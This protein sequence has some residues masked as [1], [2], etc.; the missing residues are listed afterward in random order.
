MSAIKN[1]D[2]MDIKDIQFLLWDRRIFIIF[3]VAISACLATLYSLSIPNTYTSKA[4]VAPVDSSQSLS[5]KLGSLS[6]IAAFSPIAL[7]GENTKA[8]EAIERIKSFDFFSKHF[9]SNI[10]L[11]DLLAVNKWIKEE[12]LIEY[13]NSIYS[14][15]EKKWLIDISMQDAY[16]I[17]LENIS[18][19]Q[20]KSTSFY[21]L[22]INHQSPSIAK[23]WVN[24]ILNNIDD[25]MRRRDIENS[26]NSID[27]LNKSFQLT[28][29]Q[30][31]KDA[32]SRLLESQMQTHMLASANESYVFKII[33][34]AIVPEK[35]SGPARALICIFGTLTGFFLSIIMVFI[36]ES[37]KQA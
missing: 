2:E 1:Y 15:N 24:I 17:Y 31:L 10:K 20:D 12:D 11:E 34:S 9:A 18:I 30:S 6:A 7:P 3:A 32:A 37:T 27:Y 19:K 5:S 4:I 8:T 26:Q 33:D 25:S 23:E 35:K 14:S 29:I 28:N 36:K 16:S 13:D 22:A 21:T